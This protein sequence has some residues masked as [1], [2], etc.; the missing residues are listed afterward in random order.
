MPSDAGDAGVFLGIPP[1]RG[2][3]A[4]LLS[5]QDG[6]TFW[7]GEEG[8]RE[9]SPDPEMDPTRGSYGRLADM[10]PIG[11]WLQC[12]ECAQR[13]C[14]LQS[15]GGKYGRKRQ[16]G[17]RRSVIIHEGIQGHRDKHEADDKYECPPSQDSLGYVENPS[18]LCVA[19][20][21]RHGHALFGHRAFM[22][23]E[24]GDIEPEAEEQDENE[25]YVCDDDESRY[26]EQEDR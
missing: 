10:S 8:L 20:R 6:E 3:V 18:N 2:R 1:C 15:E 11:P 25:E 22:L 12:V 7:C 4:F 9:L 21:V 26:Q 16:H 17:E 13:G 19:L 5:L 14:D 23:V 24:H